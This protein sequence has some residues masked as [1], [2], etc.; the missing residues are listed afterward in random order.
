VS[1]ANARRSSSAAGP[2]GQAARPAA[3]SPVGLQERSRAGDTKPLSDVSCDHEL[4][5]RVDPHGGKLTRV[6][7]AGREFRPQILGLDSLKGANTPRR[8]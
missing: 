5:S 8:R 2:S 4:G 7:P 3:G 6:N 1:R